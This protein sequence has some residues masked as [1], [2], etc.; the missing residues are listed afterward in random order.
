[1]A[2]DPDAARHL[3]YYA[4][5][6]AAMSIL[7]S[8]GIGVFQNQHIVVTGINQSRILRGKILNRRGGTHQFAWDALEWWANS[9]KGTRAILSAIKPGGVSLWDWLAQFSVGAAFVTHRWLQQ[10]GLDL[11]RFADDREARNIASYRPTGFTT[12]GPRSIESIIESILQI[13]EVCDPGA[14][15]GFPVL[16][17]HLLRSSLDLVWKNQNPSWR[18]NYG[19]LLSAALNGVSLTSQ[20]LGPW[21]EFLSHQFLADQ[22]PVIDSA[23]GQDDALHPDHSNQVLARA[24]LLL[25]I[26]TGCSAEL[27]LEAG[28]DGAENLEFWTSGASVR[29]RLW[30]ES[31]PAISPVDLWPDIEDAQESIGEWIGSGTSLCHHALWTERAMEASLLTTAERAFLWGVSS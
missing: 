10:W 19:Q 7:A 18:K 3:G 5:L 25:R 8:E 9:S 30:P 1:M 13:W 31:S 26:A 12:P 24:T 27:L 21:H 2:G 23:N 14:N 16:D 11:A 17:C 29:R 28:P 20:P 15:G 6:R 4:E 22:H